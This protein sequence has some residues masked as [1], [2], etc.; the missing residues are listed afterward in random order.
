MNDWNHVCGYSGTLADLSNVNC[1]CD[2][3]CCLAMDWERLQGSSSWKDVRTLIKLHVLLGE[4]ALECYN[5]LKKC[6]GTHAACGRS[7]F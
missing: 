4:Y 6:L 5:A 3:S 7:F 1:L 2:A